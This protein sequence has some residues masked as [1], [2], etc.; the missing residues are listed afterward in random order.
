MPRQGMNAT[1]VRTAA[2]RDGDGIKRLGTRA[3][4]AV[5]AGNYCGQGSLS[6][7][8]LRGGFLGRMGT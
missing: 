3:G 4:R 2:A 6:E 1:I 8:D 5:F 7:E